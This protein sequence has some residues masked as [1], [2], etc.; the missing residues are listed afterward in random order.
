MARSYRSSSTIR[1]IPSIS[2]SLSIESMQDR[3]P[4]AGLSSCPGSARSLLSETCVPWPRIVG[5]VACLGRACRHS[6]TATRPLPGREAAA[7][8]RENRVGMRSWPG[9]GRSGRRS[10]RAGNGTGLPGRVDPGPARLLRES[11]ERD[12]DGARLEQQILV[13]VNEHHDPGHPEDRRGALHRDIEPESNSE[14]PT[15]PGRDMPGSRGPSLVRKRR[16]RSAISSQ[17]HPSIASAFVM[18]DTTG[19]IRC[20]T[21]RNWVS[22]MCNGSIRISLTSSGVRVIRIERI[23]ALRQTDLPVPVRPAISR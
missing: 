7:S 13:L 6:N 12:R 2:V 4:E 23:M 9:S 15:L 8:S 14:T 5:D 11:D 18:S 21:Y 19:L 20:G 10:S 1:T 16:K 3:N 22:S 17:A